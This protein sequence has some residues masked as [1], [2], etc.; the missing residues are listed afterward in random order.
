MITNFLIACSSSEEKGK[1]FIIRIYHLLLDAWWVSCG[2]MS[3]SS[4]EALE[5]N[6]G[7]DTQPS[8]STL[9]VSIYYAKRLKK[10]S[11]ASHRVNKKIKEDLRI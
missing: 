8:I 5:S 11:R 6:L 1:K 4:D 9:S 3:D 7:V 10:K 2:L